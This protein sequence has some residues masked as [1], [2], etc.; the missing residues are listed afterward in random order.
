[1]S[2][3]RNNKILGKSLNRIANHLAKNQNLCKYLYYTNFSPLEEKDIIGYNLINEN[4]LVIPLINENEFDTAAKIAL[5]IES[6]EVLDNRDFV[7]LKISIIVYVP[8]KSWAIDDFQLRP[9]AIM[10]EIENSLKGK[11]IESLGSIKYEGFYLNT[12]DDNLASY[13]MEFY[14]DV[15]N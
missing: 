14:L 2:N 15:F 13:K 8:F 12:I 11:N 7:N 5:L 10:S 1:M 3:I 9:F 6:G 4:I